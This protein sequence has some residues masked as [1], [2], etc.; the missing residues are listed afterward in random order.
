MSTFEN[1]W[2]EGASSG[3]SAAAPS[4]KESHY[5]FVNS[6]LD[7]A[8]LSPD[9]QYKM[10]WGVD[11]VSE[12]WVKQKAKALQK[13][14]EGDV[15]T[16]ILRGT[17]L[18][19]AEKATDAAPGAAPSGGEGGNGVNG[20]SSVSTGPSNRGNDR[21]RTSGPYGNGTNLSDSQWSTVKDMRD[22][23]GGL[24]AYDKSSL[25]AA[26]Y[27]IGGVLTGL[28][29]AIKM[30]EKSYQ[31]N[32]VA[33]G[34]LKNADYSRNGVT[35]SPVSDGGAGMTANIGKRQGDDT[36]SLSVNL[37]QFGDGGITTADPMAGVSFNG[38]HSV[39]SDNGGAGYGNAPP[40]HPDHQGPSGGGYGSHSVGG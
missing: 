40:G 12:D 5:N 27:G 21:D 31:E 37:G 11:G 15:S 4:P 10:G 26:A 34:I 29:F 19:P 6:N 35:V 23:A 8:N 13:Q 28:P 36:S 18:A 14:I 39:S 20:G 16:S 32:D 38:S 7:R 9:D 1:F 2:N 17:A 3:R 25:K 24:S 22:E 30:A 33:N